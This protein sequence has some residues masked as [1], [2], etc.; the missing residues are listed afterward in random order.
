MLPN[1]SELFRI[2]FFTGTQKNSASERDVNA[3]CFSTMEKANFLRNFVM[4]VFC[5]FVYVRD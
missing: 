5:L 1:A 4:P 3:S 2:K